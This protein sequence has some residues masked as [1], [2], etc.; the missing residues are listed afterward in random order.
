MAVRVDRVLPGCGIRVGRVLPGLGVRGDVVRPGFGMRV[1]LA[2]SGVRAGVLSA[3]V[4]AGWHMLV[5]HTP[6]PFLPSVALTAER[7]W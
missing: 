6:F 2:G 5:G 3:F 7:G 4:A 1:G